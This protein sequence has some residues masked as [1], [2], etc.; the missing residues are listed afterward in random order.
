MAELKQV[1]LHICDRW[2]R[3][4]EEDK[5]FLHA[6]LLGVYRPNRLES[7]WWSAST[8]SNMLLHREEAIEYLTAMSDLVENVQKHVGEEVWR[9][10]LNDPDFV[11]AA[12][13]GRQEID[14][15]KAT[16]YFTGE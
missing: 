9:N 1:E 3:L 10:A 14:A 4:A 15:G 11:A 6:V 7:L 12:E 16:A 5:A 8:I 2:N 13:R